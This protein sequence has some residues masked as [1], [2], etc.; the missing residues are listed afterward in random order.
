[1]K[2]TNQYYEL[3]KYYLHPGVKHAIVEEF[4]SNAAIPA[5]NRIGIKNVGVFKPVYGESDNSLFVLVPHNSFEAVYND[6]EKLAS[7]NDY[8]V[9]GADFL[10]SALNNPSFV[11]MEKTLLRSFNYLPQ[12]QLPAVFDRGKTRIFEMRIYQ[13]PGFISARKKIHMFNEGGELDIFKRTGLQP[14]FFGESIIGREMPNLLYMLI[15]ENMEERERNWTKFEM[16]PDWIKLKNDPYYVDLV[17]NI[18]DIIL[19]PAPCSQI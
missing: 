18:T 14:L 6:N 11:K 4:Y 12:M 19:K 10:N 2:E 7:D 3:I 5:L 13:S 15:F 1:M 9:K 17:S 16:H 8:L